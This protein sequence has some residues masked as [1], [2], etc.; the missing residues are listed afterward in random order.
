VAG[1]K[2]KPSEPRPVVR[3]EFSLLEGQQL[4][5]TN[6]PNLAV[7]PDGRQ[8]VYVTAK[9]LYLRSMDEFDAKLIIGTERSPANPFFSP[10]GKWIGY[11]S[12]ADGELITAQ[13]IESLIGHIP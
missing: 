4:N 6:F 13:P 5:N 2:L 7:S 3:S 1:W 11:F 12:T 10:D 9:G 8:F